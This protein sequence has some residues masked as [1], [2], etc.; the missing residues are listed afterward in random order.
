MQLY[1]SAE[2]NIE[3]IEARGNITVTQAS[4]ARASADKMDYNRL[5]DKATL[6]EQCNDFG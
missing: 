6:I 2:D 1:L 5:E 4:G 3:R